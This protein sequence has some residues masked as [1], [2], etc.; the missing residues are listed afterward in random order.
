MKKYGEETVQ[1]NGYWANLSQKLGRQAHVFDDEDALVLLKA[2]LE[3][4]GSQAAFANRVG[5]HRSYISMVLNGRQDMSHAN[6]I[7][8]ALGLR[9]VYVAK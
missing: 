3:R 9:K 8:K 7:V 2:A 4:D 5:V 6:A 1:K